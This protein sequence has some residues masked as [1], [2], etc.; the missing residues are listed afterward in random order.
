LQRKVTTKEP[1]GGGKKKRSGR[2]KPRKEKGTQAQKR[3][4][5]E[6]GG[7]KRWGFWAKRL[8]SGEGPLRLKKGKKNDQRKTRYLISTHPKP[9]TQKKLMG[10][11][12]GL[13]GKPE[14]K[15]VQIVQKG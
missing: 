10:L 3:K 7:I 14:G 15:K 9:S 11:K 5:N 12:G 2:D 4:R 13:R 6:G 8:V 1:C